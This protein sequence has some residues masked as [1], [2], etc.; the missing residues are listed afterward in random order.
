MSLLDFVQTDVLDVAVDETYEDQ[1][2]PAPVPSG[3]YTL[4]VLRHKGAERDGQPILRDDIYPVIQI[5]QVEIIE[6]SEFAGRKVGLFQSFETKPSRRQRGGSDL[7]DLTRALDATRTWTGLKEGVATLEELLGAGLP[8]NVRIDW[9]ANDYE[10]VKAAL[11]AENLNG[12][13]Y[14]EMIDDQKKIANDIY[15]KAKLRGMKNFPK[16]QSGDFN[17]EWTGPGGEVIEARP[18]ITRFFPSTMVF[19]AKVD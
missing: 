13:R 12:V 11:T 19:R 2:N 3:N 10:Y 9:E 14:A 18:R 7:G 5:D 15:N 1:R 4:K 16:L 8:M 6:P 17:H